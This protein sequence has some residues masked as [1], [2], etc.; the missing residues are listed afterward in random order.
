MI[1]DLFKNIILKIKQKN[2]HDKHDKKINMKPIKKTH[3]NI[4]PKN[5]NKIKISI[6][7]FFFLLFSLL[8]SLFLNARNLMYFALEEYSLLS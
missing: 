8:F 5:K 1:T 4:N 3:Q 6:I 2:V 7:H